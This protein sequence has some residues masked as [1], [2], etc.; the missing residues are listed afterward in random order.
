[1]QEKNPESN[2]NE[3]NERKP[4][5]KEFKTNFLQLLELI[6]PLYFPQKT[7]LFEAKNGWVGFIEN[8]N[9]TEI[10]RITQIASRIDENKQSIGVQAWQNNYD[11]KANGWCGGSFSL[12]EG[13]IMKRHIML[14]DQDKWEFDQSGIPLPFEEVEKY[15]EKLV[16][17]RFTPE[18]LQR[19]LLHYGIDYFNDDFYMPEGSKAYIIERIRDKYD[20]EESKS[21][22]QRRIELKYETA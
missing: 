4:I 13:H 18:M 7:L 1:M 22:N 20:N 17:N 11:K 8:I 3:Y 16:R 6:Q 14:S 12:F 5:V 15:K 9:G 2:W 21:L 10:R 19:Y